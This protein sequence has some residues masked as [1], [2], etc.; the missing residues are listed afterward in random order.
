MDTK[1]AELQ[2]QIDE[3]TLALKRFKKEAA[4]REMEEMLYHQVQ[5]QD[6]YREKQNAL[7]YLLKIMGNLDLENLNSLGTGFD[8]MENSRQITPGP[9]SAYAIPKKTKAYEY[10]EKIQDQIEGVAS[11]FQIKKV[12]T[13]LEENYGMYKASVG[14]TERMEKEFMAKT[15]LMKK[16]VAKN[17]PEISREEKSLQDLILE[18]EYLLLQDTLYASNNSQEIR[19][20]NQI[21]K[22][23]VILGQ[24]A[25]LVMDKTIYGVRLREKKDQFSNQARIVIEGYFE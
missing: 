15:G 8:F 9:E 1:S 14:A 12:Q 6:E 2:K 3:K 5:I 19:I 13:L 7:A 4:F 24:S 23:T 25:K 11:E 20:K 17:Q 21:S 10:L 18:K 16:E 22:G